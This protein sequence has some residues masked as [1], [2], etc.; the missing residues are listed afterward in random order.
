MKNKL[1]VL[2]GPPLSGKDTYIKGIGY[3]NYDIISRDDIMM[4]LHGNDNY[5]EAFSKV[6]PKLV[7]KILN[8]KI[9]ESVNDK[10]NV[11]INMTNVSRKSRRRHLSKFPSNSYERIAVVFPILT[12]QEYENR[13]TKRGKELNKFI[14]MNV[15]SNMINRMEEVTLEEG[16]DK[17]I[18][19]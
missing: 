10:R 3:T 1:I 12:I 11:I 19:L 15:I 4:S 16:F 6:D 17:I 2:V 14:P 7:D 8:K 13:N 5:S 18:K 9:N